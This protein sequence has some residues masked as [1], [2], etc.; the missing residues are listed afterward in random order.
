MT[1]NRIS[2]REEQGLQLALYN[3]L[4]KALEP[5][6]L[7]ILNGIYGKYAVEYEE[8]STTPDK[9]AIY[10]ILELEKTLKAHYRMAIDAFSM[11]NVNALNNR[12]KKEPYKLG[13][14]FN[15]LVEAYVQNQA[16]EQAQMIARTTLEE[17]RIIIDSGLQDGMSVDEISK[18]IKAHGKIA[19]ANR[20]ESIAITE[21]HTA[22][23][24]GNFESAK[25]LSEQYDI[26]TK[27]EW[28]S[29]F[30]SRTREDHAAANGQVVDMEEDFIV[31]GERLKYPGDPRASAAQVIRC[32]CVLGYIVED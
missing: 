25:D 5:K 26:K 4:E 11:R 31:G 9:I 30:D 24:F 21:T 15:A 19:S 14:R 29:T 12:K 1:F 7:N 27:K 32:R 10:S 13:S 17:I 16:L 8:S 28:I 3:M 6:I 20:A 22:S 18:A 2:R 23:N